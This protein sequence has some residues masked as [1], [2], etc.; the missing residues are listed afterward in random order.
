MTRNKKVY[1]GSIHEKKFARK[2]VLNGKRL[3]EGGTQALA[4]ANIIM[5]LFF[6]QGFEATNFP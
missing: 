3:G 6:V 5:P 2:A 1:Y 4:V